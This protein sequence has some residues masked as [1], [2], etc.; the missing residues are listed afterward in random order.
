MYRIAKYSED[1]LRVLF[2]NTSIKF[3]MNEAII[4]K[5][6][7]VCLMLDYLFHKC[8]YKDAFTFKGGTSL[9]KCFGLI[10]RFSEDIDLILDWRILGYGLNEPWEER[11][12]SKQDKFNKEAIRIM[13]SNN[14]ITKSYVEELINKGK[15]DKS[16][17][18]LL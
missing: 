11:S 14:M 18:G 8:E 12:N 16:Y 13:L 5:D 2:R 6:F 4:E 15:L 3:G 9:S 1:E 10:K 7:W 17:G